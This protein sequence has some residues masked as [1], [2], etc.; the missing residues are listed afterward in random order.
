MALWERKSEHNIKE[1]CSFNRMK[2]LTRKKQVFFFSVFSEND[3]L[4]CL[5]IGLHPEPEFQRLVSTGQLTEDDIWALELKFNDPR[6]S[7]FTMNALTPHCEW[8]VPGEEPANV[9]Y[10]TEPSSLDMR[11]IDMHD[12]SIKI[13]YSP[14]SK[15]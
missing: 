13:D 7:F 5:V 1:I 2:S 8:T 3:N 11:L 14:S 10:V 12:Y 4:L 15:A 6:L 9:F